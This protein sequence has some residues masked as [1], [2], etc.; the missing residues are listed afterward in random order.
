MPNLIEQ[1]K[2]FAEN[3]LQEKAQNVTAKKTVPSWTKLVDEIP[4]TFR[5]SARLP[6]SYKVEGS[7]GKGNITEIPW[8]CFFD[9]DV[10][11]SAQEGYF[12]VLLFKSDMTGFYLS[13]NQGWTQYEK[14]Y[15]AKQ[16]KKE[17]A[18]NA[19]HAQSILRT[20]SSY[21]KI[22]LNLDAKRDLGKGYE[23]GNICSIYYEL[24][25]LPSE[26]QIVNDL[27]NLM[28]AYLELKGMVGKNIF[29]IGGL[30]SEDA[31][32]E[33]TQSSE[34]K[35]LPNGPI[36]KKSKTNSTNG[37]NWYRDPSIA[38]DA[39]RDA[40][41]LCEIDKNHMTFIA[42]ATG[43][44]FVEAHHIFPMEYQEEFE[45]SL[46]VP[47]NIVA[48]CPNCHRK[49]HHAELEDKKD[50]IKSLYE[51][52]EESL[53]QRGIIASYSDLCEMYR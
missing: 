52:R 32:Q 12:I 46:D 38:R 39:I 23:L 33:A 15:G 37:S 35:P 53:N 31:F 8:I 48:L 50:I 49:L 24:S 13:L 30:I 3:Y 18:K 51:I 36:N 1:I 10:T 9:K 21:E 7:I 19:K 41:Y 43:N 47:E 14:L 5:R 16:G 17:V 20:I 25:S 28:A 4:R 34:P 42:K 44:P 6:G 40:L 26:T 45:F 29:N 22:T 11:E 27:R 2:D